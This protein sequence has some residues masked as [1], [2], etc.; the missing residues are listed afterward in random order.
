[1]PQATSIGLHPNFQK[2]TFRYLIFS[3]SNFSTN[4]LSYLLL[5]QKRCSNVNHSTWVINHLWNWLYFQAGTVS[6]STNY[7]KS[8]PGNISTQKKSLYQPINSH[9]KSIHS[10]NF[11]D[12]QSSTWGLETFL[13]TSEL[14]R[15][16]RVKK[17]SLS[18]TIHDGHYS[19]PQNNYID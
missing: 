1:M 5:N 12:M 19:V 16:N 3:N 9:S 6:V 11:L 15:E 10:W 4:S 2:P 17:F 18:S 13:Y 14:N 8:I 7:I